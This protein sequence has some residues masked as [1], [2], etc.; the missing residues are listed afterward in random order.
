VRQEWQAET[1]VVVRLE[2]L[3]AR[4][5]LLVLPELSW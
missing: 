1:T 2:E 3:M 4:T 5:A